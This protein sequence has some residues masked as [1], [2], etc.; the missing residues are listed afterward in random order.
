VQVR[1]LPLAG[2]PLANGLVELRTLPLE[3]TSW[4]AKLID[5]GRN[6]LFGFVRALTVLHRN[7]LA[8]PWEINLGT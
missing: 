7:G 2:Q 6:F 1:C 4:L 5:I 3:K 8:S